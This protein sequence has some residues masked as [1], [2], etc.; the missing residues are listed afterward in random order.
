VAFLEGLTAVDLGLTFEN[1][2][3][4]AAYQDMSEEVNQEVT[5]QGAFGTDGPVLRRKRK[6]D[7]GTLTFTAVILKK[8]AQAGMN[9]INTL[10]SMSDFQAQC[11]VGDDHVTY[12]NCNWTRI[13]RRSTLDQVTIDAD[14]SIP[15]YAG[16]K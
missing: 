12:L 1:G 7:T 9:D 3:H 14:I 16:P 15:G 6:A 8:G 10:Q 4:F 11:K 5:Y 2:K 13:T